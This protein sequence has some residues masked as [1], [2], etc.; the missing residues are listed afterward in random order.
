MAPLCLAEVDFASG[1]WLALAAPLAVVLI[2][3]C[4]FPYLLFRP[5]LWVWT[6]SVY[7]VSSHGTGNVPRG[8]AL[9]VSQELA[10]LDGLLLL[11]GSPRRVR[12]IVCQGF[13]PGWLARRILRWVGAIILD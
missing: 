13:E 3:A 9:L 7:W 1:G 11:A 10:G 4:L 2:L 6:P 5:A 12:L 8:G